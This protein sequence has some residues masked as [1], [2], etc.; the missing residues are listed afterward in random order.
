MNIWHDIDSK[1]IKSEDFVAVIEISKGSKKKYELDKATGLI[2]LDRILYTST[3][4]PAN[5]GF[6]P[7]TYAED[8]DP[9]DVLVLCSEE[10][11]PLSMV[12]C[13]PVGAIRMTDNNESDDKIVAIPF[14]D[15]NWNTYQSIDELPPHLAQEI[16]HFFQV[17]KNLEHKETTNIEVLSK[18]EAIKIINN[19]IISYE[20]KYRV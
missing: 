10:L 6:I 14:K 2:I 11:E 12:R 13:Y 18:E 20:K 19:S 16:E 5:Y 1:R 17:Y 15:P 7:R 9:L 4:Y 8:D 3:H